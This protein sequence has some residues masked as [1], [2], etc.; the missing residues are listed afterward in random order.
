M[1]KTTLLKEFF[2]IPDISREIKNRKLTS[3]GYAWR[4]IGSMVRTTIEENLFGKT[5]LG[6]PRLR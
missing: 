2:Q 1:V 4:K 6:S 5:P 3:V